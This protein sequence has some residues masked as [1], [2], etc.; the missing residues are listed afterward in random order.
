MKRFFELLFGG[1]FFC[2]FQL[3]VQRIIPARCLRLEKLAF[4]RLDRSKQ[5]R[6]S[7]DETLDIRCG[8]VTDVD[9]LARDLHNNDESFRKLY[10]YLYG[11]DVKPWIAKREEK[12]VGVVW[13]Y[14]G[15]YIAP[16][17]DYDGY[18]LRLEIEP[19]A[20]F[21]ANVTV[22]SECRRQGIFSR[23]V[24]HF[25][26]ELPNEEVYSAIGEDNTLSIRAHEKIGFRRCG[27]VYYIQ[28]FGKTWAIFRTRR[29][30]SR[31][32]RMPQ[33]KTI[34]VVLSR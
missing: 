3:A 4:F 25:L 17:Q 6:V 15:Y 11:E 16:W 10:E 27:A 9:I 5:Y 19:T 2:L 21:V 1:Y 23:I 24:A 13:L 20:R 8:G 26:G 18:I 33:G 32:F 31:C 28:I 12:A 7:Q 29:G 30:I 14:Q 34:S 22:A